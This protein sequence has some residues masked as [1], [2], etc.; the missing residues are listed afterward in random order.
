MGAATDEGRR[1][2]GWAELRTAE[3]T[4]IV[5]S[6]FALIVAIP[7]IVIIVLYVTGGQ[8]CESNWTVSPVTALAYLGGLA[9]VGGIAAGAWAAR[10]RPRLVGLSIVAFNL[11]LLVMGIVLLVLDVDH[12]LS[13]D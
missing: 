11:G 10:S 3:W 5:F 9:C 4:G 13:C 7:F 8:S 12:T 1:R 2:R 6:L